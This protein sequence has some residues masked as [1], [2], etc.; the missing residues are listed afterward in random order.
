MANY[1]VTGATGYIGSKLTKKLVDDGHRVVCIIRGHSDLRL[2]KSVSDRIDLIVWDGSVDSLAEGIKDFKIDLVFH[3]ASCFIAEHKS[4]QVTDLI[5]SNILFGTH[6]LEAMLINGIKC[7][8]NT[9]T[10][11]QHYNN[12]D[13]D[14]VCLY[15]ATKEAFEQL[16]TYYINAHQFKC[17]TL[18]LFDTYGPDD[19]RKKLLHLLKNIAQTNEPLAMSA[20]LQQINLVHIDDVINAF[21]IAALRVLNHQQFKPYEF[22][23][24]A[25]G[26]VLTLKEV[27]KR[28]ELS[29]GVKLSIKWGERPY[30]ARET[31]RLWQDYKTLP[32]WQ[33]NYTFPEGI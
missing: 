22:F 33:L 3:L 23:A 24:V 8:I 29:Q 2:L 30:R 14:P 28:F 17:I 27:V 18:K 1:L 26:D 9:G 6:L 25:S 7:I 10:S 16:I 19:P 11:W 4:H 13:Y 32:N 5:E 20:G 12:A 31:M 21:L 15:A